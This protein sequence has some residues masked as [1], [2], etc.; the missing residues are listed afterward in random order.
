MLERLECV[1]HG[2]MTLD[3]LLLLIFRRVV[4]FS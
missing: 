1:A 3:A 4:Y 2:A